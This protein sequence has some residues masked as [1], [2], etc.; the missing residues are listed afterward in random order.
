[1]KI[2]NSVGYIVYRTWRTLDIG[3]YEC[4][5]CLDYSV[6]FTTMFNIHELYVAE[7]VYH[8]FSNLIRTLSTVS[9]G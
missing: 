7:C 8:I 1:M 2:Q 4:G 5:C 6:V 3:K 9:E